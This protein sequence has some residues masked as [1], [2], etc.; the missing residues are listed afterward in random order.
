[1]SVTTRSPC[2]LS[3]APVAPVPP[4]AKSADLAREVA[5]IDQ[6][7]VALRR[8]DSDGAVDAIRIYDRETAGRGQLAEDAAAI[9]VEALC[10]RGDAA[11]SAKL[12]AFDHRWPHS[13]QRVRLT[14]A[15]HR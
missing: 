3:H 4:P 11:A 8:G 13:A 1:M 7:M 15:C 2:S 6:A 12:D 9:A 14:A 5:L 10:H